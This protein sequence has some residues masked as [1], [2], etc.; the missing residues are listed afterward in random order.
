MINLR[1]LKDEITNLNCKKF[2]ERFLTFILILIGKI[3]V[4]KIVS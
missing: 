1:K 2:R 3:K 4:R